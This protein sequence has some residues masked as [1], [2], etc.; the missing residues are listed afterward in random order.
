VV[1]EEEIEPRTTITSHGK[2]CRTSMRKP[3]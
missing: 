1:N 3:G 2:M